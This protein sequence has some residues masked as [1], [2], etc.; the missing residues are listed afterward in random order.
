MAESPTC[1]FC[2][3]I[4]AREEASLIYQNDWVTSFMDIRP[5]VRGHLLIVPNHHSPDLAGLDKRHSAELF[6]AGKKLA[7]ALRASDLQCEGVNFFLAD[8]RAAG[9]TVFHVH[10][11]ILPRFGGDGFAPIHPIGYGEQPE[12]DE[13]DSVAAMIQAGRRLI[14]TT[15]RN[16]NTRS[17]A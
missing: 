13:L 1:V 7:A 17:S 12:R 11:H 6:V 8:G 10:L 16:E 15:D 9:Q 14:V 3:I 4:N 2:G 5:V